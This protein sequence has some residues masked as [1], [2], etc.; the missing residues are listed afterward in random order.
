MEAT[1][2]LCCHKSNILVCMM[3]FNLIRNTFTHLSLK[4]WQAIWFHVYHLS[5]KWQPTPI[6]LLGKFHGQRN[7]TG[8][9]HRVAELD[10]TK[11]T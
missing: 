9:V 11:V 1:P 8:T 10:T 3:I 2:D 5:R 7:L 6:F 4:I